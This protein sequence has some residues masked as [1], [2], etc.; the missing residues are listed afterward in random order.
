MFKNY[1]KIAWRSLRKQPFF[2]FLN[3]FGLAIGIAGGL[4]I[5]LYIYDEL[6]FDKMFKDAERI[7]RVNVDVKFGGTESV[8]AEV[9]A[10]MAETMMADFP[11]V[12]L[13]T[14]FNSTGNMFIRKENTQ[15]NTNEQFSTFV[16]A[17]FFEMLGLDLLS[18]DKKTALKE[19]NTVVL[20]RTA[21]QKHFG[22]NDAIGQTVIL[23][24]TDTYTVTGVIEDLPKNSFLRDYSVFM[25]MAGLEDASDTE[26]TSHNY[27]T[28][29]KLL[30]NTNMDDFQVALQSMFGTYV[31]PYAQNFF[32]G[33][34]A[35]QFEASGNHLYF[36]STPL[37]DI[38]LHSDIDGEM[39]AN[40]T[41]KNVYI[42]SFIGLFLLVLASVNFMNLST[43]HS[44]KRGKEVGIRKTLGSTKT[45]LI[46]QFLLESGLITF[47]SLVFALVIAFL[48][49]PFFNALAGKAIELPFFNPIFWVILLVATAILGLFSGWYPAFFMTR[50]IPAKVLK[51]LGAKNMG[52]SK[53]RN[54]LV[55]FQ[56]AI[57]VF[58]II[59]TL[60]VFQ[61]L[62]FIQSKELGFTKD[63]VLII[64]DA[65]AIGDKASSFKQQVG[66]LAQVESVSLTSY[67]PTP[68]SRSNTSFA[69]EGQMNQE[70]AINMQIWVVDHDYI[71]TMNMEIVAGRDF[72]NDFAADS[73]AMII[74]ESALAIIGKSAED[75]LGMRLSRNLGP[76]QD[77]QFLNVIG[78]VKDFHF[79]T[80]RKDIGALSLTIGDSRGSMAIK[81]NA[82]DFSNSI[83]AVENIWNDL[84]PGQPFAYRFMDDAFNT[85]YQ[86]EQNLGRIFVVFTILSILIACLGLFGLAAFNAEKRTKEIGV[87]KVLG[88]SVSQIAFKLTIDFL[89]LVGIAILISLPFGWY[90]MSKWLEDFSYKIDIGWQVFVLAALAAI[91]ISILTVSYQSIKAAIVNP[92][93]SLRTE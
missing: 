4:L 51:G 2:T 69:R 71:P 20:T 21:A 48:A 83:A 37:T 19:P 24:N 15:K 64:E 66:Q 78:V 29:V 53:V 36:G 35:E 8:M 41:I 33:I 82:G 3:T 34:T 59:S 68:S 76:Q 75:V 27:Y 31:I 47:I 32:P 45:S 81:L 40:S 16:D 26:W 44:L 79:E 65:Y 28:L 46:K 38:H 85:T 62:S 80:L 61:Q 56:F 23:D 43:A 87:R 5:S 18:G 25:A 74:N 9:S 55:V 10:P 30:P 12:E 90:A 91:I 63:Q 7:H 6:S 54:T 93:K 22:I 11:Q 70:D 72:N 67:L 39:S 84:A 1:I 92:V 77:M 14:R 60:I 49:L 17:S 57:S 89:K 73:T 58:L 52:D 13:A 50:F 42:L 88:A 86:A